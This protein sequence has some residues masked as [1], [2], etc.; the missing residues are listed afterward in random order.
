MPRIAN[1]RF[2]YKKR[3]LKKKLHYNNN[4]SG[5]QSAPAVQTA[6]DQQRRVRAS[7]Q[8]HR[9]HAAHRGA[10]HHLGVP[11]P[12]ERPGGMDTLLVKARARP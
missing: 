6:S 11:Q 3:K 2:M 1:H 5:P 8:G 7:Q 4:L 9:Q 10:L 12:E